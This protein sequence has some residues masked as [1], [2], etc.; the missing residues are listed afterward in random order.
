MH[1]INRDADGPQRITLIAC[2]ASKLLKPSPA[3]DL[4]IGQ[5]FK[6]ARALAEKTSDYYFILS[7]LHGLLSPD[8]RISPYNYTLKNLSQRQRDG[9]GD[10]V[11]RDALSVI[12]RAST[13]TLL[14]GND[15]CDP[16]EAKLKQNGFQVIRPLK[17][18]PIGKQQQELIRLL[19]ASSRQ[20]AASKNDK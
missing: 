9:W 17:G 10:R 19:A 13:I 2:S 11:I 5:L 16:I 8:R 20:E 4:Y 18:L 7:A 6:K 14:A 15:Y 3:K 12:P 1:A